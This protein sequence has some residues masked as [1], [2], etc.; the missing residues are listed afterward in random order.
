MNLENS[1]IQQKCGNF[2]RKKLYT[3]AGYSTF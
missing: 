2:K 3:W 1:V